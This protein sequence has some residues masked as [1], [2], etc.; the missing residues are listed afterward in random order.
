MVKH[1]NVVP[2]V[3]LRKHWQLRVK[4]FFDQPTQKRRRNEKRAERANLIAPRPTE[5]LRPVVRGQTVR[6]NRSKALGR[7]FSLLELREAK[8]SPNFARSVGINVDHRRQNRSLESLQQ[9]V[10]RLKAYVSKLVLF[11][12][13]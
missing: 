9:N 5:S 2:N 4:T 10:E 12:R 3:H 11:P 6:Y 1:N 8:L 7:G 13:H